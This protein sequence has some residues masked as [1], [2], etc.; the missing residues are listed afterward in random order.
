MDKK[1]FD[2]KHLTKNI[3]KEIIDTINQIDNE[4]SQIYET[5][6]NS[7]ELFTFIDSIA[8]PEIEKI[9]KKSALL[10]DVKKINK[11]KTSKHR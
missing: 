10:E 8:L 11:K 2:E 5:I 4:T 3:P 1:L 6:F 9:E 7:K